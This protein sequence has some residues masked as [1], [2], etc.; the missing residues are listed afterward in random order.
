MDRVRNIT[1]PA[2]RISAAMVLAL[3][4]GIGQVLQTLQADNLLNNTLIL[5][6][7]DNGAPDHGFTRNLPLR[8]Y[9]TDV[10]E[11]GIHVPFAV[12]WIETVPANLVYQE[13]IASLDIG[14]TLTKMRQL[15]RGSL[16]ESACQQSTEHPMGI[17]GLVTRFMSLLVE[18]ILRRAPIPLL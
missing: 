13:P 2:R 6:L 12:Q 14:I 15:H 4:D 1:D 10:L 9:K 7:S 5:F 18:E 3:D 11:G 8:G 16:R 17:A